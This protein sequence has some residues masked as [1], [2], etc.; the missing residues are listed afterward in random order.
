MIGIS[1]GLA[2]NGFRPFCYTIATFALYRPFEMVRIDLGYHNLPVTIIGMGAGIIYHTLGSTHHSMEDISIASS[3]PNMNVICP[4]DP[5]E[6]EKVIEW[7]ATKSIGPTYIRLGKKGEENFS[8]KKDDFEIGKIRYLK[9]GIDIA[10]IVY[11]ILVKKSFEICDELNQKGF[12]VSV[13]SCHTIKPLDKNGI[14]KVLKSHKKTI[15]MEEHVPHGGLSSRIKEIICDEKIT[16]DV[17]F[18]TL[19]DKFI[20]LYGSYDELLRLHGIEVSQIV[21]DTLK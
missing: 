10:I 16:P 18:Y 1:A 21:N 11:G 12:S 7:C 3:I 9:K 5:F 19:K 20:K 4:A 2:L 14:L 6:M 15:I 17:R 13:I 8:D